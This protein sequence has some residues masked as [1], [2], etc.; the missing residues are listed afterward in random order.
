MYFFK[1]FLVFFFF[2]FFFYVNQIVSMFF[3]FSFVSLELIWTVQ[4]AEESEIL[5]EDNIW[6]RTKHGK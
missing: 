2:S 6:L 1:L 5:S 4:I 3:S